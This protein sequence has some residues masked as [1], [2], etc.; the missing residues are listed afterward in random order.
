MNFVPS[1]DKETETEKSGAI[2]HHF[3][4]PIVILSAFSGSAIGEQNQ[5]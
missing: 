2:L 5:F 1:I 3:P 4:S